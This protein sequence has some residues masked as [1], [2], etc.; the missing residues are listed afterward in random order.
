MVAHVCACDVYTPLNAHLTQ[1]LY[2]L[3]QGT[4]DYRVEQLYIS[5][6]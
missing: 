5:D 6:K 1:Q 3:H 2:Q 4:G